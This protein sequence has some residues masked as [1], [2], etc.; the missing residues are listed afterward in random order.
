MAIYGVIN[1]SY[2]SQLL[3]IGIQ[4][5][6]PSLPIWIHPISFGQDD[7]APWRTPSHTCSNPWPRRENDEP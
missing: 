6:Y 3:V 5:F 1:A 4:Y 7:P 2:P